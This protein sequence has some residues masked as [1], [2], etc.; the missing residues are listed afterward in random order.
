MSVCIVWYY[1]VC[2]GQAFAGSL[3][4]IHYL[5]VFPRGGLFIC[6]LLCC[7]CCCFLRVSPAMCEGCREVVKGETSLL[8]THI[9]THVRSSRCTSHTKKETKEKEQCDATSQRKIIIR[10]IIKRKE[11]VEEKIPSSF[12]FL[13]FIYF[14]F[15]LFL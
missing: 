4:S 11:Y 14:F 10:M 2:S 1:V 3:G 7:C 5:S 9:I 13:F 6:S 12:S 15:I 8:S